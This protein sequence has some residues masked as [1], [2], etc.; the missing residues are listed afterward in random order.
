M[1]A[2]LSPTRVAAV[3]LMAGYTSS[4]G[5]LVQLC[6]HDQIDQRTSA[7]DLCHTATPP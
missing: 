1:V 3:R 7:V 5:L 2:P 6:R 4:R